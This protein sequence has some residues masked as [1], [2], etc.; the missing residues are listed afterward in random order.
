MRSA[1]IAETHYNCYLHT[2]GAETPEAVQSVELDASAISALL[3]L[4]KVPKEILL[5]I[6]VGR[7]KLDSDTSE[8]Q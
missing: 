5:F 4:C 7:L 2:G 6:H 3:K 8:G 1:C